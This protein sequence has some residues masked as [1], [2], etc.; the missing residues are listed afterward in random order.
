MK[1]MLVSACLLGCPCKY[2][3]GDNL[4]PEVLALQGQFQLIPICPEQMGGLPTPRPPAERQGTRVIA[5]TGT[6]VTAQ[7]MAGAQAALS[8]AQRFSCAGAILK[9]RS[10]SCGCGEIY[11]GSFG[12]IKIP[13]NGVTTDLLLSYGIPVYTEETL[14]MLP[15]P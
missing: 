13:G 10:P 12:G 5:K 8:L 3:G 9:A 14:D 11:D 15:T 6:D 2:S 7:Y 4:C 1:A